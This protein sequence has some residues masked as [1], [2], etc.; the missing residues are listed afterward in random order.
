MESSD[1]LLR[2]L[3][4]LSDTQTRVDLEY[5][6]TGDFIQGEVYSESLSALS[7]LGFQ[8]SETSH[9]M[10]IMYHPQPPRPNVKTLLCGVG[11][12]TA[13]EPLWEPVWTTGEGDL[14]LQ[15]IGESMD[16][17]IIAHG[18]YTPLDTIDI[19]GR[20]GRLINSVTSPLH[21]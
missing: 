19:S 3:Q 21:K 11:Y 17:A 5:P 15:C 7:Q 16:G 4:Y 6:M 18:H 8:R 13:S 10:L 14:L 9:P 1:S 12:A 2:R 20:L